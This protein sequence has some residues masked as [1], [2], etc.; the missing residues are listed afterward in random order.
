MNTVELELLTIKYKVSLYND[1]IPQ[2]RG[3]MIQASGRKNTLFHNHL[4]KGVDYRYPLVQYKHLNGKAGMLL[5]GE[6]TKGLADL[7][8]S[9]GKKINVAGNV[10]TLELDFMRSKTVKI[11]INNKMRSYRVVNWLALNQENYAL[12][13]N[14]VNVEDKIVFLQDIM[15]SHIMVFINAVG[16]RA[17]KDIEVQFTEID[18]DKVINYKGQLLQAFDLVMKTNVFLPNYIG[19]GKGVSIGMGCIKE[20]R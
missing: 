6:G 14:L 8:S 12:F 16:L 1:A 2:F 15:K 11:C 3:A 10:S 9:F 4:N 19:L 13:N 20:L 7:S 18:K 17:D 5:I